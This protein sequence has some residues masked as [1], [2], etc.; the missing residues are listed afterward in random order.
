VRLT[1][2]QNAAQRIVLVVA[3]GIALVAIGSYLAHKGNT[4]HGLHYFQ[5]AFRL[6]RGAGPP[7]WLRLIIWL[8][9]DGIWAV[10]SVVLLRPPRDPTAP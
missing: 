10:A 2:R 8:V 7:G 9:L 1:D 6:R 5:S 3:I 4:T